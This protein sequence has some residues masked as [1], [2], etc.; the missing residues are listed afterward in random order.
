M[1]PHVMVHY[2]YYI[3]VLKQS[4]LINFWNF[5][6]SCCI[7]IL[8]IIRDLLQDVLPHSTT[9]KLY[10]K[11]FMEISQLLPFLRHFNSCEKQLK[12]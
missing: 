2:F 6:I 10:L 1:P 9:R 8:V 7:I 5:G 12:S 11:C 4:H 3:V